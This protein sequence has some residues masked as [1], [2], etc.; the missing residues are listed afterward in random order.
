MRVVA[1]A[2]LAA[3]ALYA[4]LAGAGDLRAHIGLYFASHAVLVVLMLIV[5]RRMPGAGPA[6]FRVML[7]AAVAF[8]LIAALAPPSLSDD[9]FRYVWDGRVQASG[10]HPYRFAPADPMRAELRDA[11]VYPKIQ[12]PEVPTVHAPLAELVFAALALLHLDVTGFKLAAAALDAGVVWALLALLTAG[13]WPRDRVVLY[14][15]NPLAVIETAASGHIEPL[16]ALF[17]M[18]AVAWVMRG[19][20]VRAGAAL[21]AAI[22]AGLFPL[23]LLFGFARRMK[24]PALIALSAV[25]AVAVAPYALRGAAVPAG[26]AAFALRREHGAVFFTGIRALLE[27][28]DAASHLKAAIGSLQARWGGADAR[29]WEALYGY[30][31]PGELARIAAAAAAFAWAAYQSFRP[32]LTAA[33]EARLAMGGALL[34]APALHPWSVLWVLPLA[35]AEASGGWLLFGALVPLQYLAGSGDVPWWV[36]ITILLPALAWMARDA[37][38]RSRR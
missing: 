26:V 19:K 1:G 24:L 11:V 38:L 8:R 25:I 10:H 5:W 30:L 15:W 13:G 18:L 20:T 14:A 27:A 12:H 17:V 2:A 29:V 6:A 31:G 3:A 21:G 23:I 16:G 34:L 4:V 37:L 35:A 36:R 33:H 7:V 9:V 22:Q 32:R 28:V